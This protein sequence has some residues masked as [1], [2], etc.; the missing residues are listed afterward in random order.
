[1]WTLSSAL[2]TQGGFGMDSSSALHTQ[3]G[4]GVDSSYKDLTSAWFSC[5]FCGSG[6][7]GGRK[8]EGGRG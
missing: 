6:D 1:M 3:G 2:H 7:E 8:M 4:F 5:K